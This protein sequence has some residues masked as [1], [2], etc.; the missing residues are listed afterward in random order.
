MQHAQLDAPSVQIIESPM[1]YH[2]DYD[3]PDLVPIPGVEAVARAY[4]K[5]VDDVNKIDRRELL[6]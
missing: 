1:Y 6:P 5:L 3:R 4:A 2:T